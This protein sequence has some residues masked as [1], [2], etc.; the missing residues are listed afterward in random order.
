[1]VRHPHVIAGHEE[2]E[3]DLRAGVGDGIRII[4]QTFDLPDN[5][6]AFQLVNAKG[7]LIALIMRLAFLS[8]PVV[9]ILRLGRLGHNIGAYRF[10]GDSLIIIIRRHLDVHIVAAGSGGNS[11]AL[12][13]AVQ[14]GHLRVSIVIIFAFVFH[15]FRGGNVVKV[16]SLGRVADSVLTHNNR[17]GLVFFAFLCNDGSLIAAKLV[18]IRYLVDKGHVFV[19]TGNALE[20]KCA[21]ANAFWAGQREGAIPVRVGLKVL[22]FKALKGQLFTVRDS[23]GAH[24]VLGAIVVVTIIHHDVDR[25]GA[26]FGRLR[27]RR[28]RAILRVILD[29]ILRG[30]LKIH[31][32]VIG[33][34]LGLGVIR[35]VGAV[36]EIFAYHL[37]D[38]K[39]AFCVLV[40]LLRYDALLVDAR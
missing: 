24:F 37:A 3:F 35:K 34:S 9:V 13:G 18:R 21:L 4:C 10:G 14:Q 16:R 26:C 19:Y 23:I 27:H 11:F 30:I 15:R 7:D 20:L 25:V 2:L 36:R 22:Q 29:R 5:V 28:E 6:I 39:R 40:A 1:M 38:I 33:C 8:I 32:A 17:T 12:V 31:L